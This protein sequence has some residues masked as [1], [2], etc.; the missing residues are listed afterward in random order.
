MKILIIVIVS[1]FLSLSALAAPQDGELH[2]CREDANIVIKYRA[3]SQTW[4][5][6]IEA[7]DS[8]NV[9]PQADQLPWVTVPV[10]YCPKCGCEPHRRYCGD[11]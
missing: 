4:Y 2:D 1:L 8:S 10:D 11:D 3:D 7:P 6:H 9:N 5:W